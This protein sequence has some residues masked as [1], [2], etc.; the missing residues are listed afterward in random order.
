MTSPSDV[1][2]DVFLCHNSKDKSEVKQ[3]GQQLKQQGLKPW[4]DEWELRP[5]LSLMEQLEE[6]IKKIKSKNLKSAAVFIGNNGLGR[7][8]KKEIEVFLN[9][10]TSNK[11]PLIPVLLSTAPQGAE[12]QFSSFL[13]TNLWVD[14]RYQQPEPISQLF[15]AITGIKLQNH[16][17]PNVPI[18]KE[19]NPAPTQTNSPVPEDD[20]SSEKGVYYTRLQDLLKAGK[21]KE[22]DEETFYVM[23]KAAGREERWLDSNSIKKFPCTDLRTIDKLWV[24]YSNGHFG[25]SVQK[26]IWKSV[27]KDYD[28]FGDRVG[29]R[30]K[31]LLIA[32]W[33]YYQHLTFSLNAPRGHLPVKESVWGAWEWRETMGFQLRTM[34]WGLVA[35]EGEKGLG[36]RQCRE[37]KMTLLSHPDL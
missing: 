25:F 20:L 11:Y 2:F 13:T 10:S 18:T 21:W 15:W 26:R 17:A 24:K 16:K 8:Q 27:G 12:S 9:L 22:A 5:G 32:D 6:T 3:I 34:T 30:K 35:M 4:L 36:M 29:W 1:Q 7:W 14:F 28:K 33:S 19:N 23:L 31:V 37:C